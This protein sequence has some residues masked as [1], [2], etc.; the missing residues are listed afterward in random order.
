MLYRGQ[1]GALMVDGT[2]LVWI[3]PGKSAKV[4]RLPAHRTV[5]LADVTGAV[6]VP[7]T[8]AIHGHL[9]V[10]LRGNQP[11]QLI[12][13]TAAGHPDTI[14]FR[15]RDRQAFGQLHRWLL[16]V[17][18][19]N[20]DAR[21]TEPATE[22]TVHSPA[23]QGVRR[24]ADDQTDA[25]PPE[26][27]SPQGIDRNAVIPVT[28]AVHLVWTAPSAS[29]A[30]PPN[31]WPDAHWLPVED[32]LEPAVPPTPRDHQFWHVLAPPHAVAAAAEDQPRLPP[33]FQ[34][35]GF[36]TLHARRR[37]EV[38]TVR[39]QL[40][41]L[42]DLE[43]LLART[44]EWRTEWA[45]TDPQ[46]ATLGIHLPDDHPIREARREAL[47]DFATMVAAARDWL[48]HA[49]AT[50]TEP[51]EA[52]FAWVDQFTH[53]SGTFHAADRAF[54]EV[55]DESRDE[56]LDTLSPE[57]RHRYWFGSGPT[58]G[59]DAEWQAA[60]QLAER[61]LHQLG[62]E[63][64]A[65]TPAGADKGLD[66]AS[67]VIAAQVKYT[68]TPVGRPVLQQLQGAAAGRITAFFS[69]AGY[70]SAAAEYAAEVGMALFRIT[71]PVSV[72]AVN[73][74]AQRMAHRQP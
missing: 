50:D 21:T 11:P 26:P 47:N 71:L 29:P 40:G 8:R 56:F 57:Q 35:H 1:T 18:Q 46:Y 73:A 69:R 68:S 30:T 63:D 7:P 66:V 48:L 28:P 39:G 20:A 34:E 62:F 15:Y 16:H 17:A 33:Q 41:M 31:W 60:E 14:V 59:S 9:T 24:A 45:E 61:V 12:S 51:A 32:A 72:T 64:A 25:D 44:R 70:S 55:L 5:P 36:P 6:L 43:Q 54:T 53:R 27:T 2:S 42:N 58:P 23:Q 37:W 3:R 65:R 52:Y 10:L 22:S 74:A 4:N 49:V 67:D 13:T 19:V 38:S